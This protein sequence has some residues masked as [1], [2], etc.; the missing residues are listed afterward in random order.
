MYHVNRLSTQIGSPE[1]AVSTGPLLRGWKQQ[2]DIK[3]ALQ[4][5]MTIHAVN[6]S[7]NNTSCHALFAGTAE[8]EKHCSFVDL[9]M[10]PQPAFGILI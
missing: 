10:P 5:D 7:F 2:L 1:L 8:H 9:N 4:L 6:H 3:Q